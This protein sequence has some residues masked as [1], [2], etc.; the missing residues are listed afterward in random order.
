MKIQYCSDLHL[1]FPENLS[2]MN[3]NP[4]IPS[5]PILIL[6]GDIVPFT[7]AK[8]RDPFFDF[9]SG[10]Y[11]TA[12]W[13]PGNHEYYGSDL[14]EKTGTLNIEIRKNVFLVNNIS[15]LTSGVRLIFST[16][17]SRIGVVNE[18]AIQRGMSDFRLIRNKG[19]LL[20]PSHYNFLH[21]DC[22]TFLESELTGDES[23]KTI[24]VTHHVPTI[25]N[26]PERFRND[27][28]N[29]G[30]ATEL[31]ELIAD[32][33]AAFWI[34]GHHHQ[35]VPPFQIGNTRLLNNQLGYVHHGENYA[36][37]RDAV[38]EID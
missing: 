22:K 31:S 35:P 16:L 38:L 24:V 12:Y 6:A 13:L 18:L 8:N 14:E 33:N 36:F 9:I 15:I 17:W 27:P 4:L 28:I 19:H 1:E 23:G 30:F 5:S 2:E 25:F 34:Y 7:L 20:T 21:Q 37:R 11:E 10:E 29:E 32:S 26:Y 3:R